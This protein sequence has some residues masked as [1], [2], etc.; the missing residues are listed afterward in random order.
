MVF[1]GILRSLPAVE[2]TAMGKVEITEV[3]TVK[4]VEMMGFKMTSDTAV[5]HSFS[6]TFSP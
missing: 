3:N 4:M 2:M 5:L 1:P 6:C